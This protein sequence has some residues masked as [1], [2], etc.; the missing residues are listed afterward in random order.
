MVSE[1]YS[2]EKR[3]RVYKKKR[4]LA[5]EVVVT[6]ASGLNVRKEPS[7]D[8]PI[9]RVLRKGASVYVK[10]TKDGWG[11]I[12]SGWIMLKYTTYSAED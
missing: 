8:A 12:E 7:L 2:D 4:R 1:R 6:S 3:E 10:A 5:Q 11:A 9:V